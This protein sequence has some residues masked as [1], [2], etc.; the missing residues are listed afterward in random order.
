V[1]LCEGFLGVYPGGD[2]FRLYFNICHN[3]D[4]NGDLRNCGSVSFIPCSRKSYPYIK[5]HDSAKG[6][7]GTFFYQAEQA[8]PEKKFGL[9]SFVD[10]PAKEQDSWGTMDD[11]TMVDECQLHSRRVSKLVFDGLTGVDTIHCWISRRIQPLQYRPALMCDYSGIDDAQCYTREELTPEEVERRIRNIIKVG[12]DEE[13]KLNIPKFENGSCPEVNQISFRHYHFSLRIYTLLLFLQIST[14]PHSE[15]GPIVCYPRPKE[16]IDDEEET[17]PSLKK[18]KASQMAEDA[19]PSQEEPMA[20][21][22]VAA[23]RRG[24]RGSGRRMC[25]IGKR[26][27]SHHPAPILHG[28]LE[29]IPKSAATIKLPEQK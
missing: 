10:G 7:W 19:G 3:R 29:T 27:M 25:G 2:L 11:S 24:V 15:L 23:V 16:L 18:C 6:W 14:L 1:A 9:R 5:P 20:G 17:S 21:E 8:P 22:H 28:Q 26:V 12:R 4:S 13:L